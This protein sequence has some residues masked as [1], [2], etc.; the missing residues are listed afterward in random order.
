MIKPISP[1]DVKEARLKDVL[2]KIIE[3]FNEQIV[4]KFDGYKSLIRLNDVANIITAQTSIPRAELFDKKL[5][6][7]E[8]YYRDAGWI[9]EFEK[10]QRGEY[11][12]P[13]YYLF[14]IK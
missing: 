4:E 11:D 10:S 5:L 1:A 9:V 14:K 2:P 8:D 6:D 7:I 3:I 13:S 12:F